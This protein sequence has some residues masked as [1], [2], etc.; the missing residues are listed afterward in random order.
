MAQGI[1]AL[2]G[3]IDE[4]TVGGLDLPSE[5]TLP[6]PPPVPSP[7]SLAELR[8]AIE[9]FGESLDGAG[10]PAT[11]DPAR[12]SRDPEG[13]VAL[14][15]YGHPELDA[16]LRRHGAGRTLDSSAIIGAGTPPG[17]A[18]LVRADRSPPEPLI[19]VAEVDS[20]GPAVSSGEAELLAEQLVREA[21]EDRR[22]RR[23]AV[24]AVRHTSWEARV[25]S[26]FA[27]LVT[28]LLTAGSAVGELAERPGPG[29]V[30]IALRD[31]TD[32]LQYLEAFRSTLGIEVG[33]LIGPVRP[34]EH[35]SVSAEAWTTIRRDAGARLME[36]MKEYRQ[37]AR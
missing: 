31:S 35:T 7:V 33:T 30:W 21:V 5:D 2:M 36:M 22:A 20:L 6:I 11:F 8:G 10:R 24:E 26:R 17:P 34:D 32:G 13:W 25:R 29:A 16:V 14:A 12:V 19:R 3:E 27:E 37:R 28:E 9:R 1:A 15:T 4:L 23:R 18:A